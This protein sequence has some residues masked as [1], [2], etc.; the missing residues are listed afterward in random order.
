MSTRT[1]TSSVSSASPELKLP[2]PLV[3]LSCTSSAVGSEMRAALASGPN[4]SANKPQHA[5]EGQFPM[6]LQVVYGTTSDICNDD[7]SAK[8]LAFS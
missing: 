3:A 5:S 2:L 1:S 4:P 8:A 7:A 6:V